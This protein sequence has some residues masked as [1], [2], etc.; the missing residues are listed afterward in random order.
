MT[1]AATPPR[2]RRRGA[3]YWIGIALVLAGLGILGYL[4]WQLFGTNVVAEREHKR[5]VEQ[6]EQAW[7]EPG[8]VPTG[9][10]TALVR[11]PRFGDDYVVPVLEG[12]DDDVL[13][14]GFGHF[15]HSAEAGEVGNYAIAGHRIT[16]GEPLADMPELRPGDE[17]IV[18]TR[19][20]TH[21]YV[22]D[23]DPNE[24][25]VT[26]EDTWV[27]DALPTNPDPGGVQPEQAEDQRLITLTTCAEL[28]RTADRMIAF[29]HLVETVPRKP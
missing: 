6:T 11:I 13:R 5:L 25:I 16:H 21:T 12:I 7:A 26:F 3:S 23:T 29:G 18:E 1:T 22:L 27:V 14:R 24:L 2:T 10:V 20:A 15:E 9:D 28:F 4:A 8:P 17:V 19:E